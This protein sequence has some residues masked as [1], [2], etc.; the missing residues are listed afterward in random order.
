MSTGV[1][2]VVMMQK[3]WLEILDLA[4]QENAEPASTLQL[5]KEEL[6]SNMGTS[7]SSDVSNP[8]HSSLSASENSGIR[9]QA[10]KSA[11]RALFAGKS[12][13]TPEKNKCIPE[14]ECASSSYDFVLP[15]SGTSSY[16]ASSISDFPPPSDF[17]VPVHR[18]SSASESLPDPDP[19]AENINPSGVTEPIVRRKLA[20]ILV[21]FWSFVQ[22]EVHLYIKVASLDFTLE[23]YDF[24]DDINALKSSETLKKE[25]NEANIRNN[26]PVS[27]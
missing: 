24:S 14:R 25:D 4:F 27:L 12:V 11:K 17:E 9:P 3:D 7:S 2:H 23:D 5:A 8:G 16:R 18:T 1:K 6:L 19:N 10:E 26:M 20:G 21:V 22:L 13:N 15:E